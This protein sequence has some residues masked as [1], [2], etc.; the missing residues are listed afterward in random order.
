MSCCNCGRAISISVDVSDPTLAFAASELARCLEA[1]T[2]GQV[3]VSAP[4]A[5]GIAVGLMSD[6]PHIRIPDVPDRELDDA[7]Y[8]DVTG[9]KGTIAGVN[10]RSA[11]I[12]VYRYLTE[13]GCRWVR[14]GKDGEYLPEACCLPDVRVEETASYRHRAV[15]IEGAV[16]YEHVRDMID[17]IPKLGFSG[18]FIQFREAYEFFDRWY[19]HTGNPGKTGE[20]LSVETARDYT[21]LIVEET[22][23]RGM[24]FHKVGHGWTC[25][26][27]GLSG[28]G[29]EQ[30]SPEV[31]A[32]VSQYL[33]ELDGERKLFGGVPINTNLCYSNPQARK[34]V[35][36][37]IANYAA[38]H[39]EIDY[40]HFWLADG[41]NNNCECENCRALRPSDWYVRMLNEL[42]ELLTSRGIKTRIVFLVYVDLLWPPVSEVIKNR[43]RT[44]HLDHS[45]K[46]LDPELDSGP[47]AGRNDAAGR[48]VLMFAPITRTYSKAFKAGHDVPDIPPFVLNKLDMPR[49]VDANV[50]LLK[51]WQAS[52]PGDS[53]D[54]DYHLMWDHLNDP[55]HTDISATI[56][57]DMKNLSSIGI[58]GYVS[59]QIQRIFLPTG[60][61]MTTMGRTLWNTQT[62]FHDL[63]EDYFRSAFGEDGPEA[64][65]YL[66]KLSSLFDPVYMR[67]EK[68]GT[69]AEA[70]RRFA[71]VPEFVESFR[72][73]IEKNANAA[74]ACHAKSW[75]YLNHH[76]DITCSLA[77]ALQAQAEGDDGKARALW[78]ETRNMGF[79]K[80]PEIHAVF[81]AWLFAVSLGNRFGCAP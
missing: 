3:N 69:E 19:S 33:A 58:N 67:G 77:R 39:P 17:W 46:S 66:R 36:E 6:F 60:L 5:E 37:D 12:G 27:F 16:S 28:L 1:V 45:E 41:Y 50:A 30:G 68:P 63:S 44:C 7:I 55:G 42:D 40:L 64:W 32:E 52:F 74:N 65:A 57:E 59:C 76:A 43:D 20:K 70:A 22:K 8:I 18:Y 53:F 35:N 26:P 73:T 31:T 49:D 24:L 62:R 56:S 34:I 71:S 38:E 51:S 14:P 2:G 21:R 29:W 80:E 10:P 4:G 9:A 47:P 13:I 11:L 79:E 81:D 78:I 75:F 48:F 15:C 72:P 61:A 25:E 23:K 54:F